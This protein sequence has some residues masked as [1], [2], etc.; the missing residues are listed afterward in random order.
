MV[1]IKVLL[2]SNK[3]VPLRV[4]FLE[5]LKNY[6]RIKFNK[7][8]ILQNNSLELLLIKMNKV[9]TYKILIRNIIA[10]KLLMKLINKIYN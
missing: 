6:F 9:L 7:K 5:I 2:V 1:I 4:S 8:K 3:E 10:L